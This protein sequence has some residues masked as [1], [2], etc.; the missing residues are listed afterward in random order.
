VT[1]EAAR[2]P[3]L[4]GQRIDQR[5]RRPALAR[6]PDDPRVVVPR[7]AA[8]SPRRPRATRAHAA[9]RRERAQRDFEAVV[10]VGRRCAR[11]IPG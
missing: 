2:K 10:A 11:A 6:R 3:T 8:G 7:S 5:A 1:L 4:D 9:F